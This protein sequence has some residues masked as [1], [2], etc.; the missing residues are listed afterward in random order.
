[1]TPAQALADDLKSRGYRVELVSDKRGLKYKDM[2]KD[3]PVHVLP[4]GTLGAGFKGK[5]K[6]GL[7]L[8]LGVFKAFGLIKKLK[9]DIVVGFG[10]YPSFPAM[11]AAQKLGLKTIIHEQNAVL[12]KANA[13]LAEDAT[14]IA[15]S[16][17]TIEGLGADDKVQAVPTGNPVRSEIAALYMKP[18]PAPAEDGDLNIFI[19]GGSLGARVFSKVV[20]HALAEMAEDKKK[21][22]KIVQQCREEDLHDVRV[23]YNNAGIEARLATFFDDVAAELAACH[24]VITRS[25]ASTV[26]EVTAAGRPAMFVPYPHHKDQQQK[27]NADAVSDAGGAWVMTENGFTAEALNTRIEGFLHNPA[28][29]FQAAEKARDYAKPDA[30][31]KLGNLVTAIV[32]EWDKVEDVLK[33]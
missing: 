2:F 3:T 15:I 4:S 26:A 25:G 24:L 19:L 11:Y 21:R 27:R 1:M 10:G 12:G 18:Y 22:L 9:P 31:R 16:T 28:A 30:A 23:I 14:R 20:P 13:M 17:P 6:G 7:T 32:S 29:L 5:V 8:G 33:S